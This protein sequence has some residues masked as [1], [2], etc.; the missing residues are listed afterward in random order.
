VRGTTR[1][2]GHSLDAVLAAVTPDTGT[3]TSER[4]AFI[5]ALNGVWG[6]HLAATDN[7]IAIQMSLRIGGRPYQAALNAPTGKVLVLVHG[8]AMNDLQWTRHAHDHGQALARDLGFTPVYLHYNSGRHVSQNGRDF[9][10]LLDG[11]VANWPVPMQELVIVGH[12]MGGLVARSACRI[13]DRT[14]WMALLTKLVFLGTPH[15]GASLERG[16]QLVDAFLASPTCASATCRTPT[17]NI[18]TATRRNTTTACRRR[19][20]RACKATSSPPLGPRRPSA[21]AVL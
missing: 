21:C 12:S 15:H 3:S 17:G 18:A 11:L 10:A 9:A 19:F 5:A 20:L 8:L 7:P 16:G 1:I 2:L 6:D 14:S 13:G 4:D